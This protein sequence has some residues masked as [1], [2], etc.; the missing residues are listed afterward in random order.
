[1]PPNHGPTQGE[2]E[3]WVPSAPVAPD[4]GGNDNAVEV[5]SSHTQAVPPLA[6]Q[7]SPPNYN[8]SMS[9][10]FTLNQ[11]DYNSG[12]WAANTTR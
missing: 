11:N 3:F 7:I 5:G 6:P 8:E 10:G 1:M 12:G 2:Q 4:Y 9:S